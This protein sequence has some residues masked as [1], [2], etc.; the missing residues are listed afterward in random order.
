MQE[1][2]IELLS[3][4]G[5][6]DIP[7]WAMFILSSLNVILIVVVALVV[8]RVLRRLWGIVHR[9]LSDRAP[10]LEERKRVDTLSRIF[11]YIMSVVIGIIAAMLV[12]SELG[13]SIAPFLATA[14]VA[15]IAISFGAQS[16][17]K[18][19][20]TG[21]VMLAENQ[22]RQGDFVEVA[23]KAGRVEEVT[24]RYVRL[25]D[26]EGAVHY[27]PNSSIT[28]V[29]NHSREFAYAVVDIGVGYGANLGETYDV[30]K[31]VGWQ[32]RH[33]PEWADKILEDVEI[34]GVNQLADSAVT[35][36]LRI[37]VLALEQWGVRRAL[38][39]NL[40]QAFDSA[41]IEIPF[42]QRVVRLVSPPDQ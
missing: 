12:L 29:T 39:A 26:G 8:R 5:W 42:P 41:G 25:R 23:N 24:L 19:Y 27:V 13:V 9:T 31:H 30:I 34:L 35:L 40:K 32:L 6:K 22:I 28:T 18:D 33:D 7:A 1:G 4:M 10:G 21:F 20:F 36:R 17:V 11:G 3:S 2:L 38:L 37:K 15:G 14:G 16:L